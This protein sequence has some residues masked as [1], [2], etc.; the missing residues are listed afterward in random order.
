MGNAVFNEAKNGGRHN[1]MYKQLTGQTDDELV[2]S[3]RSFEENVKEHASKINSPSDFIHDWD[4]RNEQY[5]VGIIKK[6]QKDLTR[7]EELA[8]VALGVIKERGQ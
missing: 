1:G 5:K 7:N 4:S 2:K 8:A 3:V 6:W